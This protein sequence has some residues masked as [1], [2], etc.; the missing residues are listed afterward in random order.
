MEEEHSIS[1]KKDDKPGPWPKG[2]RKDG[3]PKNNPLLDFN[4]GQ[5]RFSIWYFVAA[6]V[7][8]LIVNAFLSVPRDSVIEYSAFKEKLRAGEIKRVEID[9][10]FLIGIPLASEQS[11]RSSQSAPRTG[12]VY[13]TARVDDPEL[14]RLMDEK[15]V[16]YFATVRRDSPILTFLLSWVLPFAFLAVIW[17]VMFRRMGSMG[18]SVMSFGRN[19]AQIVAEGDTGVRFADVAGCDEAKRELVEVVDFL[20]TP[21][22]YTAIG[23][24][25]PTG[26]LIVGPPGTGKTMLAKAVAGEAGV[27]FFRMSGS[28]FVEMFVGVGAARVRDLFK[29]AREKSPC[30]I[31]IDELDAVGRSRVNAIGGNDERET[32]LNQLLVEMDGFDSR[33]GVIILA[34]TNRPEILDPALLRPGRFDRQIVIDRPDLAGRAAILA[35]HSRNVK[36]DE[37]VDMK[38]VARST[39]GLSGADLANIVNEAALHA[40]RAGRE[41]VSQIDFSDAIEKIM[42][43]LE[44]R[45][46]VISPKEREAVAFHEAGHAVAAHFTQGSDPVEKISIIPR[47]IASLGFTLQLPT[48]ERYLMTEEELYRKID[49]LLGGRAGEKIVFG[50]VSTGATNDLARAADVARK[51]ITEYGMSTKFRNVYLPST[52]GV[53]VLGTEIQGG[54]REYS[55]STQQY[56][57]EETARIINERY[58]GV[59][60][61][62]EGKR[63]VLDAVAARLL[64]VETLTGEEFRAIATAA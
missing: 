6:I 18:N 48:E 22:K 57:D 42:A 14:V 43:G 7:V 26:V 46:K 45:T 55:E 1:P 47:G 5:F 11:T 28:D 3:P 37:T 30:I 54:Q 51:M 44:R 17:R 16:V 27:P 61:L 33:T 53:S 23:G 10:Q 56:I 9:E 49:V 25:I 40:V 19:K 50:E 2:D 39:P 64:E 13:R 59:L 62:L 60:A 34:A 41:R 63:K 52:R 31:F 35:I 15:G 8:L 12:T 32:T 38:M 29:Q 20:K 58:E 4:P 24:K 21:A 36:M